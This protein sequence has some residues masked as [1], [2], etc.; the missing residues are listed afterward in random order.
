MRYGSCCPQ[1]ESIRFRSRD[2]SRFVWLR[3]ALQTAGLA[4]TDLEP[5]ADDAKYR[6]KYGELKKKLSQVEEVGTLH[7]LPLPT[8]SEL[9]PED[10]RPQQDNTKLSVKILRSKKAIQRLRVE[11]A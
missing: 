4:Q 8:A 1:I 2:A 11:R 10:T 5:R 9:T 3:P 6:Q 7:S